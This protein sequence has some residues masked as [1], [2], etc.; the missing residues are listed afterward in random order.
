MLFCLRMVGCSISL[1]FA[2]S[3]TASGLRSWHAQIVCPYLLGRNGGGGMGAHV[4]CGL[5]FFFPLLVGVCVSRGGGLYLF[6]N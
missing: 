2:V 4:V 5:D 1:A 3:A 6:C